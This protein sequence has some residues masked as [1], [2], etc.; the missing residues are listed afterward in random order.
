MSHATFRDVV[1]SLLG[2]WRGHRRSAAIEREPVASTWKMSLDGA[3]LREHWR[4]AGESASPAPTAVA[5]FRVTESGPGDFVA[6][7][8]HGKIACGESSFADGEWRLTHR[9]LREP[10]T[11]LI[12]LRFLEADAY[13]QAVFEVADDGSLKEESV[14]IL[15]R[16]IAAGRQATASGSEETIGLP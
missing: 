14:A 10:G 1:R 2:E 3:F 9:W 11:A 12:R 8:K 7:Y 4:T 16:E 5:F 15:R 13:E 6:V